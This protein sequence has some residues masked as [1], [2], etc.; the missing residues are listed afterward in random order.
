M[1]RRTD[2]RERTLRTAAHLFRAQGYHGTG[3]NQVLTEGDLPKGSLYFHFPGGKEQLAS[4]AVELVGGELRSW[5]EA[6]LADAPDLPTG[7]ITITESMAEHLAASDYRN[8]CPV[9]TLAQAANDVEGLRAACADMFASWHTVIRDQLTQHGFTEADH[10][11]TTLIAAIEGAQLLAR[12][13]RD[14]APLHAVGAMLAHLL[15]G[16]RTCA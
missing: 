9:G 8:G 10:L 1:A 14:T 7:V 16:Q 4:E 6:I 5:I 11:A 12:N 3:V 2:T 13:Q 15:K